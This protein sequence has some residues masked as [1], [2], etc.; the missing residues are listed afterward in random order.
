M[1]RIFFLQVLL[2]F[3]AQVLFGQGA[4]IPYDGKSD[5]AYFLF[6]GDSVK[7]VCD[8]AVIMN[9]KTFSICRRAL[10]TNLKL[11]R[12]EKELVSQ[13]DIKD[14]ELQQ[15]I[16]DDLVRYDS[17]HAL[18]DSLKAHSDAYS[19]DIKAGLGQANNQLSYATNQLDSARKEISAAL[20]IVK[21]ERLK[22]FGEDFGC[23]V[24]GALVGGVVVA[25]VLLDPKK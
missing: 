10:Q 23:I 21:R 20:K 3:T 16:N 12:L 15:K 25:A 5:T 18:V 11:S 2:C 22:R 6:K 17:L 1:K 14:S 8:T 4:A 19:S 24:G 7:V 13:S 9:T